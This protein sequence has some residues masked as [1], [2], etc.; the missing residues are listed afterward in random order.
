MR[1]R[2][3]LFETPR[4]PAYNLAFEEAFML[5]HNHGLVDDTLRIWRNSNA[6]VIGYFQRAE[7]EVVVDY[8]GEIGAVIARRFTGGGAVYHDLG[9]INYAVAVS[10]KRYRAMSPVDAAYTVLIKGALAALEKLGLRAW[11]ENVNDVVVD[12]NG[13][14][15]KVSGT[16]ATY[17]ENTLFLHGSLLVSTDLEKLRR[18]LRVSK[19]KLSDKRVSSVKYR[20]TLLEKILGRRIG[21]AEITRAFIEGYRE[22]LGYAEAYLSLPEPY[23]L[24]AAELLYRRKYSARE[25]VWER[26]PV[27]RYAELYREIR[28]V[29]ESYAGENG[30]RG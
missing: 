26:P 7:E 25:W 3:L 10:R 30:R 19:K 11:L 21:Y 28:E 18:V 23:E 4:D 5:A 14:A 17:R 6:V 15:R 24:E 16:A 22:A 20:V 27:T 1:L 12:D 13:V 2:V 29:F 8:A 9:N